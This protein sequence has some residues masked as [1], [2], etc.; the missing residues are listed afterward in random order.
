MM[1][2]EFKFNNDLYAL[3]EDATPLDIIDQITRRLNQ[4]Q[5]L[6][7]VMQTEGFRSWGEGTIESYGQTIADSIEEVYSLV[8]VFW[9]KYKE[10]EGKQNKQ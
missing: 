6:G 9:E 8:N 7:L 3:R 4:A 10:V 1:T 5:T 2:N